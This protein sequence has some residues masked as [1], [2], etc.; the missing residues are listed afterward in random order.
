MAG[1]RLGTG[2]EAHCPLPTRIMGQLTNRKVVSITAAE[3]HSLCV[4]KCG[5]VYA[6][7]SNRFGQLG[8]ATSGREDAGTARCLPRR[9]DDLK[10]VYCVDVA[11]GARHSVALTKQGEVYVWGDNT[12]GQLALNRRTGT[13]KVQRVE[14]L[15]GTGKIVAAVAGKASLLAVMIVA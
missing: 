15:W 3:N 9:V 10:N 1:G 13:H 4:T 7:G 6:W 5:S 14:A 2:S 12:A 11:A 8:L